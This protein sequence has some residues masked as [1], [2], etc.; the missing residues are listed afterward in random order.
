MNFTLNIN[1]KECEVI[2]SADPVGYV[3][4]R[5]NAEDV[6]GVFVVCLALLAAAS[7]KGN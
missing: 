6:A 5:E 1:G 4:N 7:E 3:E 2:G